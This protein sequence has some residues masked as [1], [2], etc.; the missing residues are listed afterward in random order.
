MADLYGTAVYGQAVY[1]AAATPSERKRMSKFRRDP[2]GLPIPG[3]VTLGLQ[4]ID[5]YDGNTEVG[6]VTTEL[7]EFTA[8]N[9][10]LE[11]KNTTAGQKQQAAV[12]ATTAL[13]D[14]ETVWNEKLEKLMSRTEDNTSGDKAKM[15]TTGLAT[16]EPGRAPA[17]GTPAQVLN[18]SASSGDNAGEADLHWNS[19][20]PNPRLFESRYIKG[21]T[22]DEAHMIPGESATASKLTQGGLESGSEYL[23]Q[24]RAVGTGGAKG[25]WSDPARGRAA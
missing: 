14:S 17:T 4:V 11:A 16:Y 25:P 24:V 15:E 9:A 3:K 18:L 12:Q 21:L 1:S 22:L 5:N 6:T 2:K 7:A 13:N 20:K 23:F 10:D 8:A 19:M